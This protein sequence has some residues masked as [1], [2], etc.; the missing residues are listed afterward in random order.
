M[1]SGSRL[2]S[3]QTIGPTWQVWGQVGAGGVWGVCRGV[4]QGGA[5]DASQASTRHAVV[6][7]R[8]RPPSSA[9]RAAAARAPARRMGALPPP[10]AAAAPRAMLLPRV[11]PGKARA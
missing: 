2:S 11:T 1:S 10:P 8:W 4:W 7:W 5:E 3:Q 6:G 9:A